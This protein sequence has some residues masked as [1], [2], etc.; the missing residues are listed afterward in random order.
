MSPRGWCALTAPF[1][2][3]LFSGCPG[4]SSCLRCLAGPLGPY[5]CPLGIVGGWGK[6]APRSSKNEPARIGNHRRCVFCCTF[7]QVTLPCCWQASCSMVFGLSSFL[8]KCGCPLSP[9]LIYYSN[10]RKLFNN[11]NNSLLKLI[12][13]G[14]KF[15]RSFHKRIIFPYYF[16]A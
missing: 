7:R 14:I 6:Q 10:I 5:D 4:S 12:L 9:F 8:S 1:Q 13:Q 3:Y 2:P 15:Y 16:L 11:T